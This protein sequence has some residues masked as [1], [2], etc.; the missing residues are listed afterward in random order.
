MNIIKTIT[1]NYI[2]ILGIII[3]I[4]INI[5]IFKLDIYKNDKIKNTIAIYSSLSI[6][7]SVYSIY[8]NNKINESNIIDT[9]L[10][11]LSSLFNNIIQTCT[12]LFIT[13]P[14]LSYFYNELFNGVINNDDSIRIKNF[15]QIITNN[16]L[17]NIDALVNYINSYKVSKGT[18]F[19]LTTMEHKLF[20][21]LIQFTGSPIFIENWKIFQI[22][23]AL[24]WT[25]TYMQL[26]F[27]I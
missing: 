20:N 14:K 21:L 7:L 3:F 10:N 4:I 6:F 26:Y 15:E 27:N 24:P 25:K 12:N 9:E 13:N 22:N 18:N 11:N 5:I 17:M 19:Q 16:I 23:L 8:I 2:L 1:T